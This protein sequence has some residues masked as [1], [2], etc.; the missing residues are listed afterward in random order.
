MKLAQGE[1]VALEKIEN[2]YS[3]HPLVQ[4]FFVHGDGLKSYLLAVVVLDP[5]TF[6]QLAGK[7]SGTRLS[8]K[9]VEAMRALCAD[10]RVVKAVLADLLREGKKNGLKG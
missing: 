9:D 1:Y 2:I 4:Q 10:E 8:E 7:I 6:A 3:T 5:I